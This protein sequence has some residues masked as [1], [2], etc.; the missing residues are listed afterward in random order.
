MECPKGCLLLDEE[1]RE[2]DALPDILSIVAVRTEYGVRE[3][4]L[5]LFNAEDG[6]EFLGF[7]RHKWLQQNG[8]DS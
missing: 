5:L 7:V 8:G 6:Q 4:P 1:R 2:K 3:V